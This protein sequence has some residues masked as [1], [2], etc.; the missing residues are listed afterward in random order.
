MKQLLSSAD[1]TRVGLRKIEVAKDLLARFPSLLPAVPLLADAGDPDAALKFLAE[2]SDQDGD[3]ANLGDILTGA[4]G[5]SLVSLLGASR[6]LGDYLVRNWQRVDVPVLLADPDLTAMRRRI[7]QAA[8]VEPHGGIDA[9]RDAYRQGI[10]AV[11]AHDSADPSPLKNVGQVGQTLSALADEMVQ[12]ALVIAT[13]RNPNF[14]TIPLS[15]IALGKAG[16]QELNYVSD[17]DL[18]FLVNEGPEG[19]QVAEAT[20]LVKEFLQVCSSPGFLGPPWQVDVNLRPE[21][22]D[23]PLV[24]TVASALQY[25]REWAEP[26][27]MQAMLKARPCAG[28]LQVAEQFIAGLE[29]LIWGV[30]KDPQ[31]FKQARN[32]R[33]QSAAAVPVSARSRELKQSVGGLRD[34]EFTVQLLQ[35]THGATDVEVRSPNTLRAIESLGARGYVSREQT[36]QLR[37]SY[38]F[39]RALEHRV[40][41]ENMR[42]THTLPE[43]PTRLR[44]LARTME[45]SPRTAEHL[46]AHLESVRRLAADFQNDVYSR[47]IIEATATSTANVL[48]QSEDIARARLSALGYADPEGALRA[49]RSLTRGASRKARI[50]RSLSPA[51][52]QWLSLGAD[53][54]LGLASFVTLS[55]QIG[56]STWYLGTLRDSKLTAKNLCWVLSNSPWVEGALSVEPRAIAMLGQPSQL[57]VDDGKLLVEELR[58]T[59]KRQSNPDRAM[60]AVGASIQAEVT[61]LALADLL[62]PTLPVRPEISRLA[63]TAV[64]IALDLATEEW[65]EENGG[66]AP[67][68][69]AV[70]MGHFGGEENGYLSDLDIWFVHRGSG[71]DAAA[72]AG[73]ATAI[74]RRAVQ[75]LDTI[76]QEGMWGVDMDLRPEGRQGPASR[77]LTGVSTYYSQWAATWE[78]QALLKARPIGGDA[79]LR[80]EFTQM[81]NS[82]RYPQDFTANRR[83]DVRLMKARLEKE[84]LPRGADASLN[85]KLGP[86]GMIDVE[87]TV[88]LL[89]LQ[90]AFE[91]PRLQNV[92][93]LSTLQALGEAGTVGK[94]EARTLA[95]SWKF[96]AQL[97]NANALTWAMS[98]PRRSDQLPPAGVAARRVNTVLGR[99]DS[100]SEDL[101]NEWRARARA[102][103]EVVDR[104]FWEDH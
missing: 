79:A 68:V 1:L 7:Q 61:K 57:T 37:E 77:S 87:W 71:K 13:R 36:V 65:E 103:R 26:W 4:A 12:A 8:A 35:L 42:A 58:S 51:L 27:E 53:P 18:L 55:E 19:S 76:K 101:R 67:R 85:L 78:M 84:R 33:A 95:E 80:E 98:S 104:Y 100:G 44:A 94:E 34:I 15:I 6:A 90:H 73:A 23:G 9:I 5:R 59:A 25:Y 28:D 29:P 21:G 96:A 22:R 62:Q 46:L 24:R 88:Q 81:L 60:A 39:L 99:T 70:A 30:A 45:V 63:S 2:I 97:R 16:G 91:D 3:R 14:S 66:A 40:Q 47:P 93:T 48:N 20:R 72:D 38:S 69:L 74:A 32:F 89:Q 17:I 92:S 10:A 31:F 54:D 102:C 75:L 41:L 11:A 43:Q 82:F 52:L 64:D 83:R 49:V 50:Q 86:G 56:S